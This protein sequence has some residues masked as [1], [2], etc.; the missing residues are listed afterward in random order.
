MFS[1]NVSHRYTSLKAVSRWFF[2]A[3]ENCK[4]RFSTGLNRNEQEKKK[5]ENVPV[6]VT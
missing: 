6:D 5:K 3:D 2:L 4:K 1:C